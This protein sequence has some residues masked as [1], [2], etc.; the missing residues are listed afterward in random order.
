MEGASASGVSS[1]AAQTQASRKRGVA[2]LGRPKRAR[3]L[4]RRPTE[5][6][7]HTPLLA[8]DPEA[9]GAL[10]GAALP[11]LAAL[12]RRRLLA[13]AGAGLAAAGAGLAAQA[14]I[15]Q[16]QL[17]QRVAELARVGPELRLD[18]RQQRAHALDRRPDL[19]RVALVLG[20]G[21]QAGLAAA[22]VQQRHHGLQDHVLDAQALELRFVGGAEL[23]LG[24]LAGLAAGGVV[25]AHKASTSV[26]GAYVRRV[27]S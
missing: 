1:S 23:L 2:P 19:P 14:R 8:R 20:A 18:Q 17:R 7:A 25:R 4:Y 3:I 24:G 11:G 6:P 9:P 21:H 27:S 10:R 13:A 5:T 16:L 15:G 12:R 22:Q 26:L